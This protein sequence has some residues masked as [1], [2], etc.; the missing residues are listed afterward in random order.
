MRE[1]LS[2]AGSQDTNSSGYALSDLEDI[3]VSC[4]VSAKDIDSKYRPGIDTLFSLSVFDN[5]QM[6]G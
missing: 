6:K 1:K 3:E 5:I 2:S 4:E